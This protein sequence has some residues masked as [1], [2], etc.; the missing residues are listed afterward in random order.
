[1]IWR[2]TERQ[3]S[4]DIDSDLISFRTR[5]V[6]LICEHLVTLLH[7]EQ[8]MNDIWV[9]SFNKFICLAFE[10]CLCK[11]NLVYLTAVPV[12]EVVSPVF[13][14]NEFSAGGSYVETI[15]EAQLFS[16]SDILE[17]GMVQAGLGVAGL[18]SVGSGFHQ[19]FLES[20]FGR[21]S[22]LVSSSLDK[23]TCS[24][25]MES[26]CIRESV[27]EEEVGATKKILMLMK[28]LEH[29]THL[30]EE[31]EMMAVRVET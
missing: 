13:A 30:L 11:H 23:C 24:S 7:L 18:S 12:H 8:K 26:S 4:V 2:T 10:I 16:T 19:S 22:F 25:G 21:L 28:Y 1:M 20:A 6:N 9:E 17:E 31:A 3:W 27:E 15:T 29:Q 5:P 14:S